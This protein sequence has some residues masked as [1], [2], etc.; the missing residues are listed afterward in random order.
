SAVAGI[1][2]DGR[3][4]CDLCE[5][6][7]HIRV[8]AVGAANHAYFG[9]R[10][11][12]SAEPVELPS[13]GIGRSQRGREDWIPLSDIGGQILAPEHDRLG[14]AASHEY[15]PHATLS[16]HQFSTH[17]SVSSFSR[18]SN[19]STRASPWPGCQDRML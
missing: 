5:S 19:S 2:D 15:R 1:V 10:S 14:C 17:L 9:Q 6:E 8:R 13:E 16:S 3:V 4:D 18:V 11:D 7:V 12:A